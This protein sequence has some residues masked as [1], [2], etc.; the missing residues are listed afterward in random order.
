MTRYMIPSMNAL[1][2]ALY[3]A[4]DLRELDRLA[5]AEFGIPAY[6]LMSRAGEAAYRLLRERW[7][8]ARRIAV[9]CG[10]GN[11]GGD[12]MVVARL[13]H[14]AGLPCRV[15][16]LADPGRLHGEA[17]QAYDA[18]SSAGLAPEA[19]SAV[20]EVDADVVVDALLGTGLDRQLRG[21]LREAVDWLNRRQVPV[22]SLD[23]PSGLDADTG[24]AL[25][26]AVRAA[27]T[28]SF[29]GLKQG[30]FTGEGVDYCGRIVYDNLGVPAEVYARVAQPAFRITGDWISPLLPLRPRSAHKGRHGHVLLV[31]GAPGMA[32]ALRLAGEAAARVG[33]GLVTLATHPVHAAALNAVRPELICHAVA[34]P[35][36][37]APLLER[38]TVVGIGPGLGA[39]GWGLP[40]LSAV[41]ESD[42]PL[43]MDADALNWL[44]RKPQR[45]EEWILTPHPG[46]AARL[47]GSSAAEIQAD[48]W[49][50]V[51]AL[52]QRY[53]GVVVLK[54]A[55]SLV[56]R[57]DGAIGLCDAG[58]PG[59]ATGAMG[60]LLTGVIAGLL[61]QGLTPW[62]AATA[63]VYL[64]G[65]AGDLAAAEGERGLMAADLLDPLRRLV[66]PIRRR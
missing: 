59:M 15:L 6:T 33:A 58:N 31:G 25:G 49:R 7:P 8:R 32:G 36:A 51:R 16:L 43:V 64:H 18:L 57:G 45:K 22:L 56:C 63:G 14:A 1:P 50:A 30:M 2:Q 29:I 55:G 12:G 9:L 28:I 60:D 39:E 27:V 66:N 38:A 17:R 40:L 26:V 65:R 19:C 5:I 37:L 13:A 3:R 53:G 34:D 21:A 62:E 44:A 10:G 20:G 42:R 11:N 41:L 52:Q 24:N 54:G 61:A 48:R 46:E 4:R 23:I 47:L 35:K